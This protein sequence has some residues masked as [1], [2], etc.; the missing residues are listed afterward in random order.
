[1]RHR[2]L[3]DPQGQNWDRGN[4]G[5]AIQLDFPEQDR[6]QYRKD[7]ICEYGDTRVEE[8]REFEI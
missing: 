2:D 8:C 6:R 5:S 7:D 3:Q 1:M 4:L